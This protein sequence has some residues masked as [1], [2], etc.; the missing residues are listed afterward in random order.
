M[1]APEPARREAERLRQEI[2][3]HDHRYH[4]LDRPEI[5]DHEYDQ[6]LRDLQELEAAYPELVAPDSP[7]QRV[8]GEVLPGF[9]SVAHRV[10]LLSLDNAFTA[11]DLREFDRRVRAG[12]DGEAVEY[13]V[14]LKIDGLTVALHYEAGELLRGATRGDGRTGEDITANL[15]AVR[16][17]PLRLRRP[18]PAVL[19]VRGECYLPLEAFERLNAEAAAQDQ[20]LFANPRNAA[21][22][23]LRQLDPRVTASRRLDTFIYNILYID[24]PEAMPATQWG[25]LERLGE[26]G[27]RTNPHRRLCSGIEE[28]IAHCE[29]WAS[30]RESLPYEIDGL[31]VKVDSLAQQERLGARSKSPRWAIAFKFP[32]SQVVTRVTDVT[33]QLGRTGALTPT[34]ILEPVRVAGSTVSRATLHNEELVR[35]KDVRIGDWVVIQKAGDVIPE[36]VRS[37]PERRTGNEREFA[38]PT[39]CPECGAPVERAPGEAAHR[40]TGSDCPGQRREAIIHFASRD[41]MNVEGL[42]DE[43]VARLLQEGLVRDAADLYHLGYEQLVGLERFGPKSAQNLLAAID[44]TRKNPLRR[45][46]FALGIRHVGERAAGILARRFGSLAALT[47]ASAEEL[48]AIREIGPKI[49]ESVIAYFQRPDAS[50]LIDRL[51]AGGVSTAESSGTVVA[52]GGPLAGKTVVL[53]GTLASLGRKE[54]EELVERA[55]GRPS[56][57]VSRKT[58]YLVVGESP[59]SKLAKARELAVPILTEEE[60]LRL[61]E[62]RDGGAGDE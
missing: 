1:P 56:G 4:V 41:A 5:S 26:L 34:A 35:E 44:R 6:L 40:C 32:P 14:E 50:R 2:R 51:E 47:R 8:G 38:M 17:V 11:G 13:V 57:S 30:R 45:L 18:A 15:R 10:P 20:G 36:V 43:L 31:V 54:A 39:R 27:F 42:G 37:L 23:S 55:G 12:V 22:G 25:T 62:A 29:E 19:G 61:L 53:T 49:A 48:T 46:I 21:A 28:V 58:G 7:T 24:P 52:A 16:S 33:V 9:A 60:F 3:Y 59:G